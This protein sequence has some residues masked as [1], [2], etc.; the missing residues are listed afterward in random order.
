M[1]FRFFRVRFQPFLSLLFSLFLFLTWP[2]ARIA[3]TPSRFPNVVRP[4]NK[5]Q[6]QCSS[7]A[8]VPKFFARFEALYTRLY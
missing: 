4:R 6:Q 3:V 7:F 5:I 2:L 8:F 1:C